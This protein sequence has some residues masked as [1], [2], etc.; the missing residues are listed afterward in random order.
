M[1]NPPIKIKFYFFILFILFLSLSNYPVFAENSTT[2]MLDSMEIMISP[3]SYNQQCQIE[4]NCF[5]PNITK[6]DVD[7]AVTWK[8]SD[9][10]VHNI[11]SG[12]PNSGH[13]GQFQS[14]LLYT[15]ETFTHKFDL[16]GSFS[17]FCS[18][19]P[20]MMGTILIG[21]DNFFSD[22]TIVVSPPE[23]LIDG[24]LVEEYVTDLDV[25]TTFDFIDSNMFILQKNNGKV[26]LVNN[27]ENQKKT[28]LDLEV[29]NYGERGLLGITT[30]DNQVFLFFTEAHHDGGLPLANRIYKYDWDGMTLSNPELIKS[31]PGWTTGYNSGVLTSDSNK[32]VYT[33]SGHHYKFGSTQNYAKSESYACITD[34]TTCDQKDKIT[35]SDSLHEI[36]SCMRVSFYHYTTNP[37][38]WQIE[39]P[40]LTKN[41]FETDPLNILDNIQSCLQTFSFNNFSDGNWIDTG[42]VLKIFPT[43]EVMGIG[44]RNSF[45]ITTDP[46]TNHL[47]ITENG[48]DKFDE[49]NLISEKFNG[50]WA[51]VLG[52]VDEGIINPEKEYSEFQY[53]NPKFAWEVPVGV[54]GLDFADSNYFTNYRNWL[55]VADSNS[56]NI[57]YFKLNENRTDFIFES[58]ELEDNIVNIHNDPLTSS[59]YEPM[60]EILF[61]QNFGVI[62]DL[63]FGPDGSLYVSSL[64]EGKIFR[65]FSE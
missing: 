53:E 31:L 13:D 17:Y 21:D 49:I 44:I 62:T 54:T 33:I 28:I 58:N 59:P 2:N 14:E 16:E 40:D 46:I 1:L 15:G 48:P 55:F 63:K 61:G 18:I 10:A 23:I 25:P 22:E 12:F 30:V 34:K 36:F 57:Y 38:G 20:W 11:V 41:I 9:D 43:Y 45:G 19:H 50:G 51:K 5:L 3:F 60:N 27:N 4:D 47:W 29:S 26:I 56:G 8:N 64:F 6:A 37:Y 39:Q 65:I 32:N 42:V 7:T 24:F 35:F 52:I